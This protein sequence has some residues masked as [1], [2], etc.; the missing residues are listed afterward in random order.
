MVQNQSVRIKRGLTTEETNTAPK[1]TKGATC[2][3]CNIVVRDSQQAIF[4][5]GTCKQWIHRQ[6][7]SLTVDVYVKAGES[8]QSFY[9]LNCT[10]SLQ[11]QE[12]DILKEQVKTLSNKLDSLLPTPTPDGNVTRQ[13]VNKVQSSSSQSISENKPQS[14]SQFSDRKFN[15]VIYGIDESPSGTNQSERVKHD[16][17]SSVPILTKIN[18]NI[19]PTSIRDC[20]RLGK[21]KQNQNLLRPILVK[22][23]RAMDVTNILSNRSSIDNN[24]ITIKPDMNPQDQRKEALLLKERWSLI[25]SGVSRSDIKIKSSS[26]YVKGTKYGYILNSVFNLT[27]NFSSNLST[28]PAAE[29][30]SPSNPSSSN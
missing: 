25:Q 15:L 10:V 14:N 11:K 29:V 6:C 17:D 24:N 9:C 26:L 16:V 28:L 5:D 3:I 1:R 18:G 7:A 4:C 19:N 21:Y 30:S 22:L 27:P 12:I 20:F 23:N 2:P 13:S 8:Q